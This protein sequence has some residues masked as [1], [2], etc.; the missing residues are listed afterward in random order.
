M[1]CCRTAVP[2]VSKVPSYVRN[3]RPTTLR[4]SEDMNL[5]KHLC[6]NVNLAKRE[7]RNQVWKSLGQR[8][9]LTWAALP[10]ASDSRRCNQ[11]RRACPVCCLSVAEE[12]ITHEVNYHNTQS[13]LTASVLATATNCQL[14]SKNPV[15]LFKYIINQMQQFFSLLS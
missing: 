7:E 11:R 2:D 8:P 15:L 1:L 10:S 4:I 5:Q 12:A 14:I 3:C 13:V 9:R 6:Y